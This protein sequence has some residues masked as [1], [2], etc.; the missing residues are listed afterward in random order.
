MANEVLLK[1]LHREYMT[2]RN[3]FQERERRAYN[4]GIDSAAML[5]T[6]IECVQDCI[7]AIES[8]HRI[9]GTVKYDADRIVDMVKRYDWTVLSAY[10]IACDLIIRALENQP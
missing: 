3:R 7:V 8:R 4:R 9:W 6:R 2:N 5:I 1:E 10:A